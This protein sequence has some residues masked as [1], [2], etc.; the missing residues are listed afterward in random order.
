[1]K[2]KTAAF[3]IGSLKARTS[4]L[5]SRAVLTQHCLGQ[6]QHHDRPPS[7]ATSVSARLRE[8]EAGMPNSDFLDDVGGGQI[9]KAD[10]PFAK[11]S[12]EVSFRQPPTF[13]R[14]KANGGR[15]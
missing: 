10:R 13:D 6:Y 2:S 14:A 4:I 7:S 12:A 1:M 11:K 9:P 3:L 5:A 8:T 15:Q